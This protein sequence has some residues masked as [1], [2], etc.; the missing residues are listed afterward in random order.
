MECFHCK[1]ELLSGVAPYSVDRNGYLVAWDALPAWVCS[2]CHEPMFEARVVA[3]IEETLRGI[4]RI[5]ATM[6]REPPDV[7]GS[8]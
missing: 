2:A 5:M 3:A 6:S 4:D 8:P 1:G 7:R